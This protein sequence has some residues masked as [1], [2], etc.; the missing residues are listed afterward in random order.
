[1]VVESVD[2]EVGLC[3]LCSCK[4]GLCVLCGLLVI[5]VEKSA[6]VMVVVVHFYGIWV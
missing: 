4:G 6:F 5:V 3:F 2:A 1:M